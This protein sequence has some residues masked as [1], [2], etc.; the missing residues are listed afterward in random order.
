LRAD[1]VLVKNH[2]F[3]GAVRFSV[4]VTT[5]WRGKQINFQA[6][7]ARGMKHLRVYGYVAVAVCA[8]AWFFMIFIWA[9]G[10]RQPDVDHPVVVKMSVLDKYVSAKRKELFDYAEITMTVAFVAM[11]VFGAIDWWKRKQNGGKDA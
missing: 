5:R 4:W 2:T 10:E 1:C 7:D 3:C 8:A 9:M 11:F 6:K